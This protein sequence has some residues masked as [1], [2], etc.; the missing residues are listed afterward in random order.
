MTK[1]QLSSRRRGEIDDSA[2]VHGV[3]DIAPEPVGEEE[4]VA[5]EEQE[6]AELI[7]RVA[8]PVYAY[9]Q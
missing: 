7:R 1:E 5:L 4:L 2:A 6:Q 3:G 9:P 8:D